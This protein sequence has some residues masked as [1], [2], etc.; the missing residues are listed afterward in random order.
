MPLYLISYDLSSYDYSKVDQY[1]EESGACKILE[2]V[3]LLRCTERKIERLSS[4]LTQIVNDGELC[5]LTVND[6]VLSFRNFHNLSPT[7][8]IKLDLA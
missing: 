1:L 4:R 5:I 8:L 7:L 2:S 3:W 6:D